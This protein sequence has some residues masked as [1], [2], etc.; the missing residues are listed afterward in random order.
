MAAQ[1]VLQPPVDPAL[2]Q[3][4]FW[5]DQDHMDLTLTARRRLGNEGLV[6]ISDF[7]DFKT[8][9]LKEASKNIRTTVPVQQG[10]PAVVDGNG[11]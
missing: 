7:I 11:D 3:T 8:E 4:P 10:I 5:T 6:F 2:Q 9:E 1:A